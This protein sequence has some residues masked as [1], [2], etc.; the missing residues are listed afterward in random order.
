MADPSN[1]MALIKQAQAARVKAHVRAMV[2]RLLART[3]KVENQTA[4]F[5]E[6]AFMKLGHNGAEVA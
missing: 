1:N 5:A 6:L 4:N 3:R 2:S